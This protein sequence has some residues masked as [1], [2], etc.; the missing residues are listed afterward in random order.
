MFAGMIKANE[1]RV[2]NLLFYKGE[3][4]E[5]SCWDFGYIGRDNSIEHEPIP[6]TEERLN[7]LGFL[8]N[9]TDKMYEPIV[10]RKNEFCYI[11]YYKH[12]N[13]YRYQYNDSSKVVISVNVK[14]VHDIQNVHILTGEELIYTESP[15]SSTSNLDG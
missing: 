3:I 9:E 4:S 5:W 15:N 13:I 7:K 10:F 1:L 12:Q 2:G 6:I 11:E 14:S 8:A